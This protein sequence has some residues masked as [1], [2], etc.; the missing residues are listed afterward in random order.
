MGT[1]RDNFSKKTIRD[2]A[3]RAGYRCSFPGCKSITIGASMENT[4]KVSIIGVA[5]HICAAAEGGP[6]YDANMTSEERRGHDNCI[7]MCQ[8]HARLIDTDETLYTVDKLRAWKK[9]AEESASK[10][11]ANTDYWSEY[12]RSN[13]DN[14]AILSQLLDDMIVNGQYEQLNV[15]LQQYK[16]TLSEQYGELVQRYKV[17][18]DIYCDRTKVKEDL[19]IYCGLI[20]KTGADILAKLFLEFHMI[21]ELKVIEEFCVQQTVKEYVRLAIEERLI[22]KLIAP[23]GSEKI[24]TF[25]AEIE[26]TIVR[27]LSNYIS[28]NKRVGV[29]EISG[30]LYK[31]YAEEFYYQVVC[32]S[33]ELG[34]N[35]IYGNS[36]EV[37]Q[38]DSNF[39][40]IKENIDRILLLDTSLQEYIWGQFLNAMTEDFDMFNKYYQKCPG[41]LKEL[42]YVQ[43]MKFNSDV[44][45]N[46]GTVNVEEILTYTKCTK[47]I[48]VL[49]LYLTSI[50]K[51]EAIQ[52]LDEHGYLFRENSVFIKLKLELASD[53]TAKDAISFLK[54]YEELFSQDFTYHCML[55]KYADADRK[56]EEVNWLREHMEDVQTHDFIDYANILCDCWLWKDLVQLSK[57]HIPNDCVF[58]IAERLSE[59]TID[60]NVKESKKLYQK[61]VD[62]GWKHVGLFFNLGQVQWRLGHREEAKKSFAREYDEYNTEVALKY[63]MQL[64][65]ETHEYTMDK[66]YER[67]KECIDERSQNLVAAICLKN[68][69]CNDARKY[70]LRSLLIKDNDNCSIN[71]F[72]KATSNAPEEKPEKVKEDVVCTLKNNEETIYIA[73]HSAD[74]LQGISS[75]C[76]LAGYL[77][78]SVEDDKISNLLLGQKD[79]TVLFLDKEYI[80]EDIISVN[81]GIVKFMFS[82]LVED[83]EVMK[84]TS[85]SAEE[86]IAQITP[87]LKASADNLKKVV[88]SYNQYSICY[89]LSVFANHVGKSLLITCEFLTYGNTKKIT[90][91][92]T[93]LEECVESTVF[94][95]S[96]ESI[97]FLMHM[98][99]KL[100]DLNGV[101]IMCAPQVKNQLLE[102]INE[103]LASILNDKHAGSMHYEEGKITM[104]DRN[105]D[106]RRVR[107]SV[108][109]RMKAFVNMIPVEEDILDFVSTNVEIKDMMDELF[110]K[111]K[112]FCE[113]GSLSATRQ[114]D[115]RVLVTDSH[116]LTGLAN[117][118]KISNIGLIGFLLCADLSW[119]QLLNIS[120]K[121]KEMNFANYLPLA[122]YRKMVE[123]MLDN[124]EEL[125]EPSCEIQ[126]WLISDTDGEPSTYHEDVVIALC[127]DVYTQDLVYLNP[128]NFLGK[129]AIN[130]IEKRNP[131]Y[132]Q[133]CIANIFTVSESE[134]ID[135]EE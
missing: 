21:D 115:N 26:E 107:H 118:E 31:P 132:I 96:Y 113:G 80:I 27:S 133:Q 43:K 122:L 89:P 116:F 53:T 65:Y 121:L 117:A 98:D 32:A 73:I 54:K 76:N 106:Y 93:I 64:R 17:I 82:S 112:L 57:Y 35:L 5:A 79:E 63:L 39:L 44:R 16:T 111:L 109:T 25:P 67:L 41:V 92:L 9:D 10:A 72:Y 38:A 28:L 49:C 123:A 14:L 18:Y 75:P 126:S 134:F 47:D 127:R 120:K 87:I 125:E 78:Y 77:H 36:E 13:G 85:S 81:D 33:Y 70:F 83:D 55:A 61:L 52:F 40:F 56:E 23:V 45:H 4:S 119:R 48:G 1:G 60:E 66:Y 131:G 50:K 20:C 129:L 12:Y 46:V 105:G 100:N 11:L 104:I 62:K 34:T 2:V 95:L 6:R 51:E 90:N 3:G 128:D 94:V 15:I 124:E 29:L 24:T 101:K 135:E 30:N 103:E 37:P 7:W 19:E 8:T 42:P 88:D 110:K 130:I 74:I 71:G 59:S 69:I 22:D 58:I 114:G 102:D 97:V 68:G 91:N 99:V 108:L 86:F 84:I